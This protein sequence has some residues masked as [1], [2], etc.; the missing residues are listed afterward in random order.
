M[1][2]TAGM[3]SFFWS[4]LYALLMSASKYPTVMRLAVLAALV[5]AIPVAVIAFFLS[6]I[7]GLVALLIGRAGQKEA[8]ADKAPK[9][10]LV[11][12]T[13]YTVVESGEPRPGRPRQ[14]SDGRRG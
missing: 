7:T 1:H 5:I 14:G 13:E 8:E 2:Q 4:Q 3:S 6:M 11:I 12:E 9:G 10:P